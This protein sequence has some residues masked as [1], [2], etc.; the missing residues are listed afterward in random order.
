MKT[1]IKNIIYFIFSWGLIRKGKGDFA[2]VTFDDGPSP[3]NTSKILTTLKDNGVKATFFM[4]GQEMEKYPDIVTTVLS[5]GHSIGYHSYS[6]KSLKKMNFRELR[7]DLAH[8]KHLSRQF[9]VN[10]RLY[11]PPYGELTFMSFFWLLLNG[12]KIVMWSLDS[13]DSFDSSE[14]VVYTVRPA[15]I[16]PGE[17]LLFHD[18][19]DLTAEIMKDVLSAYEQNKL[20]VRQL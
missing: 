9:G 1:V 7:E 8:Y 18:D 16:V 14:Q 6:H 17:I 2:Y 10:N 5:E 20:K 19:Y 4:V 11:R 12:W 13:R 3:E 15:N